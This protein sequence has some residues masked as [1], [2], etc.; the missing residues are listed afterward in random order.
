MAYKVQVEIK[1]VETSDSSVESALDM[2][3][4]D[5]VRFISTKDGETIDGIERAVV[6]TS[7]DAMRKALSKH[8]SEL[9]KKKVLKK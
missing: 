6:D 4:S 2:M 5:A 8:L 1:I 3:D 9:S 7:Y